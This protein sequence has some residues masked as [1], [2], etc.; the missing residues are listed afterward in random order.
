MTR[1]LLLLILCMASGAAWA[2]GANFTYQANPA[3][4]ERVGEELVVTFNIRKAGEGVTILQ[5][6]FSGSSRW[7]ALFTPLLETGDLEY[8]YFE[9][10]IDQELIPATTKVLPKLD[11][12]TKET[13]R[14]TVEYS[15]RVSAGAGSSFVLISESQIRSLKTIA[16]NQFLNVTP[17]IIKVPAESK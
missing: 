6:K 12:V 1:H 4:H 5:C 3:F 11:I 10:A 9:I 16:Q 15:N 8:T 17:R 2:A 14:D 7:N 13:I